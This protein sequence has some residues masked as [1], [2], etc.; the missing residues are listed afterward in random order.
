MAAPTE[1]LSCCWVSDLKIKL[2]V[3]LVAL[4]CKCIPT[5]FDAHALGD[6]AGEY[7]SCFRDIGAMQIPVRK[8]MPMQDDAS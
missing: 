8:V 4:D 5:P 7:M 2:K 3:V 1:S 6:V